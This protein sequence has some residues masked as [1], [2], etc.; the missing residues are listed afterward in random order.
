MGKLIMGKMNWKLL[1]LAVLLGS[2]VSP[3]Q[4]AEEGEGKSAQKP[5]TTVAQEKPAGKGNELDYIAIVGDEKIGMA[6]YIGALRKGMRERF[7]HG[8]TP[9]D[10]LKEYRKEVAEELV[11]RQLSI[12]EARRRGIKPDTTGIPEAKEKFDQQ[13]KD[14]PK[15]PQAREKVLK[16]FEEKLKNDS[17]VKRLEKQVRTIP[18]PKNAELKTFYAENKDL[19]TT[20]ERVRVSLILLK[21]DPSSPSDVWQQ[22]STEAA[23]ILERINKG[24]DFGELARIHSGDESAQNGGDMGYIHSGMLG[25]NAQ[26]VLNIMEPG[27]ISAPAVL[28]EGVALFKLVDRE[29]PRLNPLESVRER[30]IKLYQRENAEKAWKSLISKLRSETAIKYNDAPWR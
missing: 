18:A 3:G 14:D 10:Q 30:A 16:Q 26:Q 9:E 22:A 17:L 20:P 1:P 29:K 11:D 13:Y 28:L 24:G 27:E 25:T 19:F 15:W 12:Q 6:H 23:N 8:K 5:G 2:I 21:V 4:A 7:Y